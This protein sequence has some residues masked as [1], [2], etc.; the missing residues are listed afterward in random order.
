MLLTSQKL[1]WVR[2]GDQS[3]IVLNTADL[4]EIQVSAYISMLTKDTGLEVIGYIEDSK[5]K[6]RGYIGMG[7]ELAAQKFCDQVKQAITKVN[8]PAQKKLPYWLGG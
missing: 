6:T 8:P 2:R 4:K 5:S 3:G 7:S 1:I